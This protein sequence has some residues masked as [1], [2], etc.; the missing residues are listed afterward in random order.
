MCI[1]TYSKNSEVNLA[2][3]TSGFMCD[4]INYNN[5]EMNIMS[6]SD[7]RACEACYRFDPVQEMLA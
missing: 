2:V 3:D 4:T 7:Y 1:H 6:S 5:W